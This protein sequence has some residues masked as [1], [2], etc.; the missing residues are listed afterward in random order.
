MFERFTAAARE[1]VIRAKQE[2]RDLGPGPIG[3]QHLLLAL[4]APDA[5]V[6]HDVLREAGLDAR[7]GRADIP[8]LGRPPAPAPP[9]RAGGAPA[10][11]ARRLDP[12]AGP[13]RAAG[14]LGPGPPRPP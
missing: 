7:R 12:H 8:R 10:P 3:T 14:G 2:A 13:A 5:G 11:R 4:T 9:P 1:T 6:A